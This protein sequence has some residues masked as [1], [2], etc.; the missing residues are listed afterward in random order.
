VFAYKEIAAAYNSVVFAYEEIAFAC[1]AI[2][3]FYKKIKF[4]NTRQGIRYTPGRYSFRERVH[5]YCAAGI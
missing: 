1:N 5:S 2:A 3:F 4:F